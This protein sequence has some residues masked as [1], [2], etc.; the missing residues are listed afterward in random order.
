M[1]LVPLLTPVFGAIN[2]I[3]I[4]F[5][6]R[7]GVDVPVLC[8]M[9]IPFGIKIR[10]IGIGVGL[11]NGNIEGDRRQGLDGVIFLDSIYFI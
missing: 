4:R 5:D 7:H 10:N 2:G 11:K 3:L 9:S 1:L 8:N 6:R